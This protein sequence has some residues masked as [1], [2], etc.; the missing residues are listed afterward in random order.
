[1]KAKRIRSRAFFSPLRPGS[2]LSQRSRLT[3]D[4]ERIFIPHFDVDNSFGSIDTLQTVFS[5]L[6]HS[7][8]AAQMSRALRFR[9]EEKQILKIH[10][11]LLASLAAARLSRR[12]FKRFPKRSSVASEPVSGAASVSRTRFP[13]GEIAVRALAGKREARTK[14]HEREIPTRHSIGQLNKE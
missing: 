3:F 11:L 6:S 5:L 8:G 13:T 9:P 1:M 10:E 2:F 4:A 12:P 7:L 14:T